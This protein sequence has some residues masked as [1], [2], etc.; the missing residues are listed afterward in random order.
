[1]HVCCMMEQIHNCVIICHS[2]VF[3]NQN[4][5]LKEKENTELKRLSKIP[6]ILNLNWKY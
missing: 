1:M 4:S 5:Q 6:V 2:G 3:E